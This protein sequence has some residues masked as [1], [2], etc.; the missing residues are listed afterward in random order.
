MTQAE[1]VNCPA[2]LLKPAGQI[3]DCGILFKKVELCRIQMVNVMRKKILTGMGALLVVLCVFLS[4]CSKR[5]TAYTAEPY[6]TYE[7]LFRKAG[8]TKRIAYMYMAGSETY[9]SAEALK[10][11]VGQPETAA[12]VEWEGSENKATSYNQ[13]QDETKVGA[14]ISSYRYAKSGER[15]AKIGGGYYLEY[16]YKDGKLVQINRYPGEKKTADAEAVMTIEFK[17]DSEGNNT[18]VSVVDET[19]GNKL[20]YDYKLSYDE[21]GRLSTIV[22]VSEAGDE[23][24]YTDFVYNDKGLVSSA[25]RYGKDDRLLVLTEYSY[26]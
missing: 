21:K 2:C 4:G 9:E 17:Y 3:L 6:Y 13:G 25:A 7:D 10:E 8:Y 16:T 22:Y 19:D 11:A 15:I 12:V 1:T 5:S 18:V 24:S 26:E 23:E 20:V 14:V